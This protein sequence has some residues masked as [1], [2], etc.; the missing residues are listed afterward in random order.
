MQAVMLYQQY[1]T[2]AFGLVLL[3]CQYNSINFSFLLELPANVDN[4]LTSKV[5]IYGF[6]SINFNIIISNLLI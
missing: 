6:S 5:F 2:L 4:E 1:I 3:L